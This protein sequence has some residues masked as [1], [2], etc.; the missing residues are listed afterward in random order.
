MAPFFGVHIDSRHRSPRPDAR[1]GNEAQMVSLSFVPNHPG[2]CAGVLHFGCAEWRRRS[3][4][5][6]SISP[7]VAPHLSD[8]PSQ[9]R[10]ESVPLNAH[11][12]P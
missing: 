4:I 5:E 8:L 2:A 10:H 1:A 9:E 6:Y 7:A 11:G 3:G 12:G